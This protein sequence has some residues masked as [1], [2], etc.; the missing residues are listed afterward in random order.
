MHFF[1]ADRDPGLE[2]LQTAGERTLD[3]L[4]MNQRLQIA[5]IDNADHTFKEAR[6]RDELIERVV[7]ELREESSFGS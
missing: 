1:F 5:C 6:L 7:G 3:K 4:G 2:I